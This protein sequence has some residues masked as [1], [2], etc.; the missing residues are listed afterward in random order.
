MQKR[1]KIDLGKADQILSKSF[2][3]SVKDLSEDDLR[4]LVV[5][6]QKNI[7]KI[8]LEKKNDGRLQAAKDMVKDLSAAYSSAVSHEESKTSFLMEKLEEIDEEIVYE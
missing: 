7:R 2:V 3:D 4:D 8:K 6:C 5:Q 1:K